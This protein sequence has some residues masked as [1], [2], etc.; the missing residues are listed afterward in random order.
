M[1]ILVL[2]IN[3]VPERT[4]IAP[5]TTGLC[6]HLAEQ[7]HDVKVVT[8]FPYYPSWKV[9]EG[10]RGSC[11]RLEMLNGVVVHRVW[12]F[13]PWR[14]SSL[15]QR[16]A[17]DL[18]FT[19]GAFLV[20]LFSGKC[21]VVYC[22][23]P[24]PTLGLAAYLLSKIKRSRFIVKLAD[25][26]SDAALATGIMRDG[27]AIRLARRLEAFVYD[28]AKSVVC[29][30]QAFIERLSQRQVPREKLALIPDWGD[31]ERIRPLQNS[32]RFREDHDI[33]LGQFLVL[34]TGNMGKKQDLMN[35]V[36][37]AEL[38]GD[39]QAINWILVGDGEERALLE[40]ESA[41][42][43]SHTV[44]LLPLQSAEVLPHMY[45][46]ADLLLLNQKSTVEDAVIPS[47]LLTYMAAGCPIVAAVSERSE[48]AR[49]MALAGCGV[50]IPSE[51]PQALADTVLRLS[52]D[53]ELRS[54][55][56]ANGRAYAETHFTKLAV[57]RQ[58]DLLF[59]RICDDPMP[60]S[61]SAKTAEP[62]ERCKTAGLEE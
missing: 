24:P 6:E 3:Y 7:G 59:D 22:C 41:A 11:Y 44:R 60:G 55:L 47:K 17:H 15:W 57:L 12:H 39:R 42:R 9:F 50:V 37:A 34:H 29:L 27:I 26:A 1:R 4:G 56:G 52:R 18:S 20:G 43:A 31:T 36:K 32:S 30:C 48:A 16:L 38:L 51:N 49:H 10:Y 45:A 53:P 46:E 33:P 13:V 61:L 8:A 35:A 40:R 54:Q 2:G 58:Y 23:C 19:V 62:V 28:R 14:P 21:D 25:L 5:F